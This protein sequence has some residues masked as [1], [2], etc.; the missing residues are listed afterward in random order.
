MSELLR[1]YAVVRK[2]EI[3]QYKMH[4]KAQ[5]AEV[6][7]FDDGPVDADKDEDAFTRIAQNIEQR[8]KGEK[9]EGNETQQG[10]SQFGLGIGFKS[11]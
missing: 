6:T 8:A 3:R 4:I 5:G 11:N 10:G 9:S 2:K 1:L 7:V